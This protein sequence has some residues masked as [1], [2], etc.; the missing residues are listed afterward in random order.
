MTE[1]PVAERPPAEA[2]PRDFCPR[3]GAAYEPL[4]EYC[5]ECG[6]RLPTNRGMVGVL[7][8]AWQRRVPWYP[9][10]FIW[11][12][13]GFLLLAVAATAIAVATGTRD[14]GGPRTVAATG[15]SVTLGP[16]APQST[17]ATTAG[18]AVAPQP[19]IVTGTLP[20]PPGAPTG[21]TATTTKPP[22]AKPNELVAWPAGKSGYTIV[23]ESIPTGRGRAFADQRA[24]AARR[25]GLEQVGVL[26]TSNYS[27]LHAGYYAVFSGIFSSFGQAS[28]ALGTARGHGF[29]DAFPRQVTH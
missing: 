25:S 14:R 23:L 7:A 18:T 6:E 29:P 27:S 17:V 26:E 28:A 20:K 3:C 9:G 5:L 24:R 13:L 22:P 12:T 21:K 19:T 2:E 16:A 15:N 4:Q 11:P 10:D 8:T 1:S